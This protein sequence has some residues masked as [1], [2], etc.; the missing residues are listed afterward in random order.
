MRAP[1]CS[2]PEFSADETREG[3]MDRNTK[4]SYLAIALGLAVLGTAHAASSVSGQLIANN[5]PRFIAMAK[6]LGPANPAETIDVSIWL[7]PHNREALDTL[8]D[9]LYDPSSAN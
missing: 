5:T 2:A 7:N 4:H 6:N 3:K 8:T 9:E 1:I